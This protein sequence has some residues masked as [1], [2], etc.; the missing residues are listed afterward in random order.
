[1]R[2]FPT[3]MRTT[4]ARA[5]AAH[6]QKACTPKGC[7][8][9]ACPPKGCTH[10]PAHTSAGANRN[11]AGVN[12]S[13]PPAPRRCLAPPPIGPPPQPMSPIGPPAVPPPPAASLRTHSP[14]PTSQPLP[15]AP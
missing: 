6:S 15:L 9:I 4:L 3:T 13:P 12:T 7:T 5:R 10:A 1:M 8:R 2:S 14:P 11:Q